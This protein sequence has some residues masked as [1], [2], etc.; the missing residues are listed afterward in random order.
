MKEYNIIELM[1]REQIILSFKTYGIEGTEM[2]VKELYKNMP[3]V[4]DTLLKEYYNLLQKK[5]YEN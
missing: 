2:K 4:R 3:K 1:A 5:S